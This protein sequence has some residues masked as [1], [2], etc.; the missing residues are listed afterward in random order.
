MQYTA[1]LLDIEGTTTSIDFVNQTLFPYARKHMEAF[2]KQHAEDPAVLA[3]MAAVG[4]KSVEAASSAFLSQMDRDEKSTALKSLQ[5]KIWEQGYSSGELLGQ[6]YEDVAPR[7]A[8]WK[9]AGVPVYIYSSGSVAAQKL[10]FGKSIA[11]D[12]LPLLSGHFD[13]TSGPKKVADSYRAIAKAIEKAPHE[14]LFCTDSMAEG[15][16][17]WA[18][19]MQIAMSVRTGNPPLGE[20]EFLEITSLA[21]L[22]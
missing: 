14:V 12:L 13:T 19:G 5:G 21:E 11:G 16:A 1:V 8:K 6:V 7:L 9:E 2:L 18:A 22:D 10:I 17:A 15:F 3:D 4:A 20:H